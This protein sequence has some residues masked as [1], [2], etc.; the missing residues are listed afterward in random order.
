MSVHKGA[1]D[2]IKTLIHVAKNDLKLDDEAYRTVLESLT[3]KSSTKEMTI[4]EM[5]K[6]MEAFESKGFV[7]QV[8][9]KRPAENCPQA[10]KIWAIWYQLAAKHGFEAR[11]KN[12]NEFIKRQTGIEKIEWL[13]TPEQFAK[14]IEALKKWDGRT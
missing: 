14:V 5:N 12:L 1:L 10:K 9:G 11:A 8:K 6:V 13:Q 7:R 2:R 4:A 3:G